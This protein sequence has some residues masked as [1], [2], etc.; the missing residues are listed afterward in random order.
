V[1]RRPP[2]VA[3]IERSLSRLGA[4]PPGAVVAVSGGPDS[5]ALL[6]AMQELAGA[7]PLVVAHLNHQLRGPESD[8]DEA[9][10]R[11]QFVQWSRVPPGLRLRCE[12]LDVR[13]LAAGANIEGA[14]RRLRYGW[15][16]DVARQEGAAAVMTGHTADDQAETVLHRLLRGSGLPGLRGIAGR[17]ELAP[18]V[19]LLRPMLRV[20]RSEVLAY[21]ERLGQ[22]AREDSSNRD[23]TF[24]RNRLRHDLLPRLARDY[25]PEVVR[26]LGR[27][28]EQAEELY[29]R[30]E[31]Q[32]RSLLAQAEKPRAGALLVFDQPAL[33]AAPAGVCR[34]ALRLAW[35]REG[36]PLGAMGF[37][38]WERLMMVARGEA[39]AV[40]LPGGVA[41]RLRGRV[42]Q[43]GRTTAG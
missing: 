43:L 21:L 2:L 32:A 33:A 27:L 29:A 8:A 34:G 25:N 12:R 35:Q 16:A 17:R 1:R 28:A 3:E 7:A 19:A 14:A 36:W 37:D 4:A 31:A 10:V 38:A 15:L 20:R 24:T 9:F 42:L 18:G 41:A 40:D 26:T 5:V 22:P 23:T 6:R 13:S 39:K 30:E 11:E